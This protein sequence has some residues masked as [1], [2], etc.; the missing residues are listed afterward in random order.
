VY[1]TN[2]MAFEELFVTWDSKWSYRSDLSSWNDKFGPIF[3]STQNCE[4]IKNDK[5]SSTSLFSERRRK[6]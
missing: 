3:S 4:Y 6:F 2:V 1:H 5:F